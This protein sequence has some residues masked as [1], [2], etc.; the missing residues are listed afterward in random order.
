MANRKPMDPANFV[1]VWNNSS[2]VKNFCN[3]TGMS[4]PAAQQRAR[5][6]RERGVSLNRMTGTLSGV[7]MLRE[8]KELA[9]QTADVWDIDDRL[10]KYEDKK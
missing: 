2:S 5:A 6:F 1:V 3:R 4:R 7:E 8:I 10:A 9:E